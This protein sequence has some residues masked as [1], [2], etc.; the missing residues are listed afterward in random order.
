MTKK[1]IESRYGLKQD[2][3]ELIPVSPALQVSSLQSGDVVALFTYEP[4]GTV[5]VKRLNAIK[6]LQGPVE[7]YVLKGPWYG[8][9]GVF[10]ADLVQRRRSAA[11]SFRDEIFETMELLKK[12]K[13]LHAKAMSDMQPGLSIDLAKEVPTTIA[14]FAKT[15]KERADLLEALERQISIY[16]DLGLLPSSGRSNIK[17]F[18]E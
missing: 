3:Y 1:F 14:V 6:I 5:L 11:K 17:I 9:I 8:G 10:S 16:R 15:E 4:I 7:E 2:D 12:D 13:D 18:V